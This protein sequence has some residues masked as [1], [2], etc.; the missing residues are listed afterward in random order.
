MIWNFFIKI[1]NYIFSGIVDVI[2]VIT[3]LLPDS[4]I[5]QILSNLNKNGV[6]IKY[7]AYL[8]YFLPIDF[9]LATTATFLTVISLYYV[10]STVLRFIKVIE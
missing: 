8:N 3:R 1:I 10:T 5:D 4:K 2:N 7:I 6:V 9:I